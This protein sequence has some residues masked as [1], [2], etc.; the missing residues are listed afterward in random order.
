MGVYTYYLLTP[1]H[2]EE[3]DDTRVFREWILEQA[4]LTREGA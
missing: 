4:R 2:R 3:S 1:R